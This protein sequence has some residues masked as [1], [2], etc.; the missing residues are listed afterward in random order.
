MDPARALRALRQVSLAGAA[1]LVGA[2]IWM[3]ATHR[4]DLVRRATM[5]AVQ[6]ARIARPEI[7]ERRNGREVWRLVAEEAHEEG[8]RMQLAAPR[9]VL[10]LAGGG[11]V[12]VRAPAGS[13]APDT[14]RARLTGGAEARWDTWRLVAPVLVYDPGKDALMAPEGFRL[15]R[16]GWGRAEGA[17]LV[18][19]RKTRTLEAHGHVRLVVRR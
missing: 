9:L 15:V 13:F 1:L 18:V 4:G 7:V 11:F 8:G 2:G 10:A 16:A 3:A 14:H 12:R 19:R 17:R 5:V 6:G